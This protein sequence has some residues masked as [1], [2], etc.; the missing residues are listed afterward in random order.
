MHGFAASGKV[1]WPAGLLPWCATIRRM[2]NIY[3]SLVRA[4]ADHWKAHDNQY[5]RKIV[6]A[7]AQFDA[8]AQFRQL[9]RLA[10]NDDRPITETA[11]LGVPLEQDP[12]TPGVLIAADGS[13]MAIA[14]ASA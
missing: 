1:D 6:L 11:F 9:G 12:A 4:I 13:E 10:L 2:A 14:S 3:E 7:P 8:L 5:P